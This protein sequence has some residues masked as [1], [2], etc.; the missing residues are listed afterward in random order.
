MGLTRNLVK[1]LRNTGV[2]IV[3]SYGLGDGGWIPG[4]CKSFS[5]NFYVQTGPG[6]HP[7]SC[8]MGTEVLSPGINYGQG[9]MLNTPPPSSAEVVNE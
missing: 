7:A 3:P 9:V 8:P 4:R 1:I 5:S 6:A 2:S